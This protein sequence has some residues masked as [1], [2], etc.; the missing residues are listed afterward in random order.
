MG[1]TARFPWAKFAAAN[2]NRGSGL[3]ELER[4]PED[5]FQTH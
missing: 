3:R 5:D 1:V 2:K 4:S